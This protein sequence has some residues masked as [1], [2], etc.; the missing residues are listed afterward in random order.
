MTRCKSGRTLGNGQFSA[1]TI[2][3]GGEPF[4]RFVGAK[5]SRKFVR[6][7][8]ENQGATRTLVLAAIKK[9][10]WVIDDLAF[11]GLSVDMLPHPN[12]GVYRPYLDGSV[13]LDAEFNVV[14]SEEGFKPDP[15]YM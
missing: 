11:L 7:Y 4:A 6:L 12:G 10:G 15:R 13:D 1:V 2:R 5:E 14:Y 8:S 3:V 9:E